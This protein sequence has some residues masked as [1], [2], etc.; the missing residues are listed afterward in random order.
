M[1]ELRGYAFLAVEDASV[2]TVKEF[3]NKLKDMFAP[4]KTVNEYRGELSSIYQRPGEEIFSYI[5]RVK[6]L[7]N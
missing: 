3:G 4:A 1:N 2:S 6:N 5:D 7:T